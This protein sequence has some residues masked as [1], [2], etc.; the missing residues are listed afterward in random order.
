MEMIC[1]VTP[2][3]PATSGMGRPRSTSRR[4]R[5]RRYC[6]YPALIANGVPNAAVAKPADAGGWWSVSGRCRPALARR[7]GSWSV[8]CPPLT[9][10]RIAELGC[11]VACHL[12]LPPSPNTFHEHPLLYWHY[13]RDPSFFPKHTRL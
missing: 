10:V 3:I 2:S 9:A 6:D 8:R 1:R 7:D 12:F 4:A 11:E 13:V 5:V